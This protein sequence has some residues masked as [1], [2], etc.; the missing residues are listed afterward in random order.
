MSFKKL[1]GKLHLWLGLVSG[2]IIF[3]V[4]LTG[5]VL[6]FEHEVKDLF[7]D[8][9][10]DTSRR[11]PVLEKPVLPPSVLT[12]KL[13]ERYPEMEPWGV[14]YHKG[15]P[16][17]A[18]AGV[19]GEQVAMSLNPYTGEEFI[20]T[21]PTVER[22]PR[23]VDYFFGFMLTGHL[24]LWLPIEIGKPLVGYGTLVFLI[25]LITG[26]VLWWPR[27]KAGRKQ[28]FRFQWKPTTKW[29]RKNY[30][31]HNVL[32]FYMTWVSVFLAITGLVMAFG[33]FKDA[34]FFTL[35]GGETPEFRKPAGYKSIVGDPL[36]I[37]WER[38]NRQY[39]DFDGWIEMYHSTTPEESVFYRCD[40]LPEGWDVNESVLNPYTLEPL[41]NE[42]P[43]AHVMLRSNYSI[44]VGEI[45]GIPTKILAFGA[46]LIAASLPVTGLLIW[47]G[48]RKK[49]K[50][51]AKRTRK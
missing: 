44:H 45:W 22:K 23:G 31:L 27:N 49:K 24:Y 48:R 40:P 50:P 28:R 15:Y 32:G 12:E 14:N 13:R 46:S 39:P 35:S 3:I 26:I 30:D 21:G 4:S 16:S 29:K 33:W 7:P 19:N 25:L 6:V 43:L 41:A 34:W 37:V 47:W 1:I 10:E 42:N 8:L 5:A 9:P 36:D 17:V 11:I 2:I 20:S 18:F 51:A 38:F